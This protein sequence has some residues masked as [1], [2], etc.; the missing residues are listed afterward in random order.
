M[1]KYIFLK[2]MLKYMLGHI[3]CLLRLLKKKVFFFPSRVVWW[4]SQTYLK[5]E[6]VSTTKL[7]F[8]S[9]IHFIL[10]FHWRNIVYMFLFLS[11]NSI[12]AMYNK[13][14]YLAFSLKITSWINAD[15]FSDLYIFSY[16]FL[17]VL[18]FSYKKNQYVKCLNV[19]LSSLRFQ[20]L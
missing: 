20:I 4:F 10:V 11:I 14:T 6:I 1:S 3:V 19:W 17:F 16:L 13:P 2:D 7:K 9:F 18:F 15:L 5:D 12:V 8:F